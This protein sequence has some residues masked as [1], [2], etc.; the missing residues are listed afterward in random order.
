[1]TVL[2]I[3]SI[4]AIVVVVI[5]LMVRLRLRV[6]HQPDRWRFEL[7]YGRFTLVDTARRK[8][9]RPTGVRRKTGPRRRRNIPLTGIIKMM[10]RLI[11]AAWQGVTF[12]LKRT[13]FEV[14]RISG[15]FAA[16]DPAETGVLCALFC[17]LGGL[18]EE[19]GSKVQL[20]VGPE[21]MDGGTQLWFE[22][23]ASARAGTLMALPFVVLFH[24]PKRA[25][26]QFAIQSIRR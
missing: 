21:F 5:V 13:R 18:L 15:T 10:P 11:H 8:E 24:L 19:Q 25:L 16:S 4:V 7:R 20:A 12:L 22:G 26:A 17:T 9:Q 3:P 23:E 2:V 6:S 14:C 1:M